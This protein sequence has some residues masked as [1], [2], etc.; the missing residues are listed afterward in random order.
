V[1]ELAETLE[2]STRK[3]LEEGDWKSKLPS[4]KEILRLLSEHQ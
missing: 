3:A 4:E 1:I 2:G